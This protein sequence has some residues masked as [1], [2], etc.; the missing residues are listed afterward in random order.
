VPQ[1]SGPVRWRRGP[2]CTCAGRTRGTVTTRSSR[3]RRLGG[4]LNCGLVAA[5]R[6]QGAAGELVGAT[7]RAPG[8]AIGGGAHSSGGAME[9]QWRMLWAAAF[10]GGEGAP[11]A[12]SDGG[13]SLQSRRGT[14]EVRPV[15][16]G[17]NGGG[18]EVSS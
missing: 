5:V 6:R 9:R 12:G 10:I 3:A 1:P 8:K 11:V 13:M 17:D 18:W 7:G 14:G 15:S 2:W 4:V 16:N